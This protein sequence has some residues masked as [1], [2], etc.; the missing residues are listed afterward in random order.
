MPIPA[1]SDPSALGALL[2][3]F[4]HTQAPGGSPASLDGRCRRRQ[5]RF[6]AWNCHR[7]PRGGA[8][9]HRGRDWSVH[10]LAR[11]CCALL[12]WSLVWA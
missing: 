7:H 5:C 9:T 4:L 2:S 10:S 11:D 6:D 12:R 1:E 3:G 8:G